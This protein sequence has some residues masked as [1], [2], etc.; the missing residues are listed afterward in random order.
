M[1]GFGYAATAELWEGRSVGGSY[2]VLEAS[3]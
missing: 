1:N 2:A 3:T